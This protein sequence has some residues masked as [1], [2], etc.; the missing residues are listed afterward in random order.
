MSW[1][2]RRRGHRISLCG[3]GAPRRP[4]VSHGGDVLCPDLQRAL[5]VVRRVP[6]G[7]RGG[8]G[9]FQRRGRGRRH[10]RGR[11]RRRAALRGCGGG[12]LRWNRGAFR[13]SWADAVRRCRRGRVPPAAT[14]RRRRGKPLRSPR[15]RA[16]GIGPAS[17]HASR[18]GGDGEPRRTPGV[19]PPVAGARQ[20]DAA[21]WDDGELWQVERR[22]IQG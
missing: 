5:R 22:G 21:H 20:A 15:P 10:R 7:A 16:G 1:L 6:A 17:A 8:K 12:R 19:C 13:A 2:C 11:G 18:G 9:G 14:R 4:F 3:C